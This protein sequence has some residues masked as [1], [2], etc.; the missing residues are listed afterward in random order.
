MARAWAERARD[1]AS[2]P[3]P[4]DL[5]KVVD[6]NCFDCGTKSK[7]RDW[8]FLGVQCPNCDSFNTSVEVTRR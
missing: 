8:H 3:M 6:I 4:E 1:I 2:Q 5:A 7:N